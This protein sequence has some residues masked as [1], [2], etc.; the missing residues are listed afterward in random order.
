MSGRHAGN[1]NFPVA[2]RLLPAW[3][4]PH[5]MAFYLFV[6]A[7]DDVADAPGFDADE[8]RSIL[9]LWSR[10][11]DGGGDDLCR[12]VKDLRHSL[13]ECGVSQRHAQELLQAFL[14][15]VANPRTQSWD[16]LM[17]YCRL[18]AM[19]VGRYLIELLDGMDIHDEADLAS[20]D[21]LCAAL[22]IL[23]HIQ[24]IRGDWTALE[25]VYIPADWMADAGV[26]D[27]DL[28]ADACTPALRSVV[29]R[30]LDGV[31]ALLDDAKPLPRV[32]RN[33]ALAREAGGILA[34]AWRLSKTLRTRD[35]LAGR[36]ELSKPHA[37]MWFLWGAFTA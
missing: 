34:I 5:V 11:L 10:Q 18:S 12:P 23:N 16:D 31:D 32:I 1:E 19:P 3:S 6:R 20:S 29:N 4:R 30:M 13:T 35:P 21:A 8:K 27:T 28:G 36:V 24:D 2:S 17:A 22:Q 15:D 7:A 37:A 26:N 25:R 9:K 33:K 14:R